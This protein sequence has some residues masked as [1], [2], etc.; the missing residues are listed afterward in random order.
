MPKQ[1]FIVDG[2][3]LSCSLY[4]FN[5]FFK[6]ITVQKS[7][8]YRTINRFPHHRHVKCSYCSL[9]QIINDWTGPFL[10]FSKFLKKLLGYW[11]NPVFR[12][13]LRVKFSGRVR[14]RV[15][16]IV[17]LRLGLGFGLGDDLL[18]DKITGEV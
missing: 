7:V 13:G 17:G 15:D 14:F 9:L 5:G 2:I 11:S 10:F 3:S 1:S 6:I 12:L 8:K 4:I 16:F 18:L